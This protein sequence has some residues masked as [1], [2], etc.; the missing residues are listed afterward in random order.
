VKGKFSHLDLWLIVDSGFTTKPQSHG[1]E[2]M[3]AS[4]TIII[5]ESNISTVKAFMSFPL[6]LFHFGEGGD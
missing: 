4:P 5:I 2:Y 1:E 6:F 3:A